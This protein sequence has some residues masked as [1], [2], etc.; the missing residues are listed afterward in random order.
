MAILLPF[1]KA[2]SAVPVTKGPLAQQARCC[3]AQEV[4]SPKIIPLFARSVPAESVW[5]DASSER[6]PEQALEL[7][8]RAIDLLTQAH[9]HDQRVLWLLEDCARRV[10]GDRAE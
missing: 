3:S 4:R 2:A 5:G 9:P 7:L 8:E 6:A 1:R 10:A